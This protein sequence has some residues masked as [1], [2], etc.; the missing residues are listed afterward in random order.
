MLCIARDRS[1]KHIRLMQD[2]CASCFVRRQIWLKKKDLI[3]KQS[4]KKK[5]RLRVQRPSGSANIVILMG[6]VFKC[7][8][9]G[10]ASKPLKANKLSNQKNY[11]G[12]SFVPP[13]ILYS[14]WNP[15]LNSMKYR[16]CKWLEGKQPPISAFSRER[17]CHFWV[18]PLTSHKIL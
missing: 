5:N 4:H 1:L 17:K 3:K 9:D 2:F 7:S 10:P 11:R 15:L 8:E 13:N 18:F 14:D 6:E 12:N 16:P